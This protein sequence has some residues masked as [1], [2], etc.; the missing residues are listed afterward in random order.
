M[1]KIENMQSCP[2]PVASSQIYV[3][4]GQLRLLLEDTVQVHG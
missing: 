1:G 4:M 2:Q 3:T